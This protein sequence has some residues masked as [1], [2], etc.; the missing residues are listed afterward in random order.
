MFK[1]VPGLPLWMAPKA[2]PKAKTASGAHS[3]VV[4]RIRDKRAEAVQVVKSL[5][6]EL[7]KDD[8]S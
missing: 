1:F 6:A 5:R 8:D 2:Q 4:S 3:D 7:R